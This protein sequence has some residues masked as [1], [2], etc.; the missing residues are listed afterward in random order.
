MSS[1]VHPTGVSLPDQQLQ[2]SVNGEQIDICVP[3]SMR[4]I[5]VLRWQLDLT[6]T[7]E[8]CSVGV[9]GLCSVLVDG[10]LMSSCL[11][12]AVLVQGAVVETIEGLP[13]DSDLEPLQES[14]IQHGAVQCG[15][16]IPGQLM[17]A[18]ALLRE[19]PVPTDADIGSWM[20]GNLCRCTGYESIRS[21][22]HAIAEGRS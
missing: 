12:P 7:K 4:L 22:I 19:I 9:C 20:K 1:T 13:P 21:A 11:L 15:I 18:T 2:F 5:D 10:R 14:F 3:T 17:A 8:G 6:G 16:C